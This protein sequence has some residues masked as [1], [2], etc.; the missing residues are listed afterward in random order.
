MSLDVYLSMPTDG[1]APEPRDAIFV[2]ENGR[3]V[4][5]T[6]EEWSRRFPD[7]EPVM[8]R[9]ST[10]DDRAYHDN[11]TH[12]LGQMAEAAGIYKHLWR[13]DEIGVTR[14][15]QLIEPLKDGLA[16]LQSEPAKFKA[17]DPSNGWGNYDG[18]VRF[19]ADY[20]AACIR[21]PRA[22]VRV[23]R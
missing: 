15:A 9:I 19:V 11:I 13:P 16:L 17:F 22:E 2:R 4:E 6:R 12:N 20:L 21:M 3:T 18:L 7:R 8:V 14:A 5:I 23:S 10:D 1:N